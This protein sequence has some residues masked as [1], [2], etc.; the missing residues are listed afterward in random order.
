ML[1]MGVSDVTVDINVEFAL[2]LGS[3]D[4]SGTDRDGGILF[5]YRFL[6]LWSNYLLKRDLPRL[7]IRD[8]VLGLIESHIQR[9]RQVERARHTRFAVD[10]GVGVLCRGFKIMDFA[11]PTLA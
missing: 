5:G 8:G 11:I 10:V 2:S 7:P 4:G 1:T 3:G 6:D 9:L